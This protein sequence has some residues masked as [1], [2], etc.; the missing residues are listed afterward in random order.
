MSKK[1]KKELTEQEALASIREE[2]P[3]AAELVL[4]IMAHNEREI[5]K[6]FETLYEGEKRRCVELENE[7]AL[8]RRRIKFAECRL[9]SIFDIDDEG[10]DKDA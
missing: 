9:L 2:S 1:I 8:L 6:T 10:Y 5:S 7:N 3:E 4:G